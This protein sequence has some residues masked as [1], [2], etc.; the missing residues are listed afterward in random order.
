MYFTCVC[1]RQSERE[2]ET[3]CDCVIRNDRVLHEIC[4]RV[5]VLRIVRFEGGNVGV[6]LGT[7]M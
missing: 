3:V 1:G 4:L 2:K 7:Y 5:C 6:F